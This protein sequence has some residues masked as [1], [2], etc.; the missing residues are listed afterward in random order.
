MSRVS[1]LAVWALATGLCTFAVT[2]PA[3]ANSEKVVGGRATV[4]ASM[5]IAVFLRSRGITVTP[6]GPAKIGNGAMTMPMVGGTVTV[7]TMGGTMNAKGGLQYKNG[8]KVVRV[9]SY[10]LTHKA[11]K[12]TLTA[13]VN[14]RRIVIATMAAPMEQMSG[15]TGTMSGGLMLSK[16]WARTINRLVGM[17]VVHAGEKIG[18]LSMTLK[19]S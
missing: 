13:I 15:K 19:M 8:T 14:G 9:R 4:K 6:I 1:K 10:V 11:G 18:E 17:K 2:A 12:A 5:Q 7:P 16:A 3:Q